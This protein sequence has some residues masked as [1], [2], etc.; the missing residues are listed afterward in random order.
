MVPQQLLGQF[1]R[2]LGV[3]LAATAVQYALLILAVEGAQVDPTIAS[4]VGFIIS[5][6]FNY[7][8]NYYF[9]FT[10]RV[11]HH[12]AARRFAAVAVIG[13]VLNALIMSYFHHFTN[14]P[15]LAAQIVATGVVLIWNFFGNALWTY[16]GLDQP[17]EGND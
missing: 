15:Y 13:L 8:A 5:A 3:G 11:R 10:S 16:V 17:V 7:W 14:V 1:V 9:T 6:V 2:F 4:S 12:V